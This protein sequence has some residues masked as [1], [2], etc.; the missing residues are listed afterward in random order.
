[1]A[2]FAST[3]NPTPFAFFDSDT[4]FQDDAD[5]MVVFVRRSLGDDVLSVELTS[6]MVWMCF[7]YATCEYSNQ[8]AK[9]KIQSE[10]ANL[11]GMQTGSVDLIN[12][13]PKQ[14]LEYLMRQAEPYA[15][16]A[17]TGGSQNYQL[18]YFDLVTG[19]QDYDLYT[20]L[21]NYPSGSLMFDSWSVKGKMR[22]VEVFHFDPVAA[23][24]FLLNAANVTNYLA[25]EFNYE[26][27]VN[28]TVFYV[29]PIFEDVLRRGMLDAAYRVRRSHY[30]YDIIGTKLRIYPTPSTDQMLG[31]LWVRV[32]QSMDPYSGSYQ[33]DSITG[34]S[35]PN[36]V[37]FGNLVYSTINQPGRQ[38]IRS[39]T[40]A[41]CKE[42]LGT[43][44]SKVESIPMIGAELRLDG[45]K[46]RTEGKEEKEKLM[47]EFKEWLATLTTDKM[48]ELNALR[49]EN[50]MKQLRSVP[51][52]PNIVLTVG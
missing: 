7:E 50:V 36:N 11:L 51:F 29:L 33:D 35:G 25:T 22:I 37:P 45:D 47:T 31:K 44:R 39:Y 27:Y 28:S 10:L 38:W 6:K 48:L 24:H 52:P 8:I 21:R 32:M 20:E 41:L 40:L 16:Q 14:T 30:S 4:S 15:S 17:G 5:S 46:L 18:G 49:A 9:M 23:Q 3:T 1:M 26:S 2:S 42:L 19:T 34:V 43:V 12:K 13:Y